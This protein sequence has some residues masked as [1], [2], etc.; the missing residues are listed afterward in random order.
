MT[1]NRSYDPGKAMSQIFMVQ[2][3]SMTGWRY[4]N[5][6]R[7]SGEPCLVSITNS[8]QTSTQEHK[9]KI[10]SLMMS[11]RG[12]VVEGEGGS[13]LSRAMTDTKASTL[14]KGS[15]SD[16]KGKKVSHSRRRFYR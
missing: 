4:L 2:K 10:S 5:V 16:F 13:M 7:V 11:S 9:L 6:T 12:E 14:S 1:H 3:F 8:D 15:V